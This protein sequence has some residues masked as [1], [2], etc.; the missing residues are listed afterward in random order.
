MAWCIADS[1][2][3]FPYHEIVTAPFVYVRLHGSQQL[4]ESS[5]S[6]NEL[7]TWHTRIRQWAKDTFVYFDNDFQGYA[8]R[9]AWILKNLLSNPV[10]ETA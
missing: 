8:V 9:N 5:Y 2:G 4:Y 1:A 3:R 10:K 6:D 7:Q